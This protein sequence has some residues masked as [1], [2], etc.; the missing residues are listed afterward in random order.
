MT[1]VPSK[2]DSDIPRL[3][4]ASGSVARRRMLQSAGLTFGIV[5]ADVDEAAIR[6]SLFAKDPE[7]GA[8]EIA[9]AL[10][11][12]KAEAVSAGHQD[13]LVIG[14]DQILALGPETIH[15]SRSLEEARATLTRLGG[16]LH[17]LHSAVALA[18]NGKSS[19]SHVE[20]AAMTMRHFSPE[21]LD[22]YL[23][24]AGDDV[25]GSVGCYHYEGLGVQLFEDVAGDHFTILGMP[26]LPLLAELRRRGVLAA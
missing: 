13:A 10:A 19:W 4:L 3:I 16:S 26:L 14:S 15:K 5:P 2:R 17:H 24:R 12:A 21:W 23:S 18:V 6:S 20:C 25:L 8:E 1:E 22:G 7:I 9:G 11:A